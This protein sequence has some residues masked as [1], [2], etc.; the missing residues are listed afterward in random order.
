MLKV[1]SALVLALTLGI[2]LYRRGCLL[3]DVGV[4]GGRSSMSRS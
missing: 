3:H 2:K 1:E 4:V